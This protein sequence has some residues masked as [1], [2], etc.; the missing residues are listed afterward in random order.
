MKR[1]GFGRQSILTARGILLSCR[2]SSVVEQRFCKPPVVGSSPTIGSH[3]STANS[4]LLFPIPTQKRQHSSNKRHF[5]AEENR[6]MTFVWHD[7]E[8]GMGNSCVH[9]QS[10]VHWVERITI[11][12]D[13]QRSGR[14]R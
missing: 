3:Y 1:K 8:I 5:L 9:F 2:C 11:T 13:D 12:I 7:P 14:D 4:L 10:D 6:G